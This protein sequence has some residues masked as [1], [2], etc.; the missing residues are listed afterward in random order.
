MNTTFGIIFYSLYLAIR[1]SYCLS[2]D[3]RYRFFFLPL[4]YCLSKNGTVYS[5]KVDYFLWS[6]LFI[7]L[8]LCDQPRLPPIL[9]HQPYSEKERPGVEVVYAILE[10]LRKRDRDANGAVSNGIFTNCACATLWKLQSC[11][12]HRWARLQNNTFHV[13]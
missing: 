9:G 11:S 10:S 12:F 2:I 8:F 1:E 4:K 13:F 3:N 5:L 6:L 7:I